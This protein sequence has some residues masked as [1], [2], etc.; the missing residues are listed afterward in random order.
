[1]KKKKINLIFMTPSFISKIDP[2]ILEQIKILITGGEKIS[3]NIVKNLHN[4][5]SDIQNFYGLT[6][7]TIVCTKNNKLTL[8]DVSIGKPLNNYRAYVLNN[9]LKLIPIGAIGELHI[10]GAGLARGYLNKPELTK[11]KFIP[12]PFQTDEEKKKGKNSR[13][14]K[15]GDLV[16]WLPDGNLDYIGRND[17]QVKIRGFRIELEEIE[18]VLLEYEG[19]KQSVVLEKER[20]KDNDESIKY[21]VGYYVSEI[22]IDE[23]KIMNH[24]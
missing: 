7:T 9:E 24:L 18:S 17:F 3:L 1:M 21:L 12:N 15:T 20:K 23:T 22:K 13:I 16:R 10:G 2:I 19:I 11:E 6:E 8:N 4:I 5:K 14:Y